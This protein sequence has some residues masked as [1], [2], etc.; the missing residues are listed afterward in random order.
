MGRPREFDVD[1]ALQTA[2]ELFWRK[3]YEGTSLSDLTEGMGITRP[4]LYGAFGN[5]EDLFRKALER[6]ETSHLGFLGA[7]LEQPNARA[8]VA[9]L[10]E[11]YVGALT[12]SCGPGGCMSINAALAC[13]EAGTQVQR[14]VTEKRRHTEERLAERLARAGEEG[15][16]PADADPADVARYV[17]TVAQGMAVQA[18]AGA[19]RPAL[20]RVVALTLRG[21][22]A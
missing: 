9:A 21:I 7:A 6:Y 3:G 22:F 1:E 14:A 18:A 16:L 10:L 4:S 17:M 19:D 13:S 5:K 8:V 2:M 12:A 15:D 20:E 11:G